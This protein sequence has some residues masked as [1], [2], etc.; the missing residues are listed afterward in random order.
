M[1]ELN[2]LDEILIFKESQS[3]HDLEH[4]FKILLNY[5]SSELNIQPVQANVSIEQREGD[6]PFNNIFSYAIRRKIKN[7]QLT[8]EVSANYSDLYPFIFLR[9]AFYCF[10]PLETL[11]NRAIA[12]FINHIVE[13]NLEKHPRI[14]NWKVL[15]RKNIVDKEYVN[16]QFERFEKFFKLSSSRSKNPIVFFF[17]YTRRNIVLIEKDIDLF[18]EKMAKEYMF[19]MARDLQSDEMIETLRVLIEIFQQAKFIPSKNQYKEYFRSLKNN[20]TIESDLSI[21]KFIENLRWLK[22]YSYIAPNYKVDYSRIGFETFALVCQFHPYL[23]KKNIRIIIEHFPFL[24]YLRMSENSFSLNIIGYCYVPKIYLSDFRYL[25]EFLKSNSYVQNIICINMEE[26][27]NSLNLNYFREFHNRKLLINKKHQK[28]N[29][30][31]EIL[32][33]YSYHIS[34]NPN[35]KPLSLSPLEFLILDRIRYIA[36]TGFGFEHNKKIINQLKSDY[37]N[38]FFSQIDF[39]KDLRVKLQNLHNEQVIKQEFYTYL[40]QFS[41][42]GTYYLKEIFDA[43]IEATEL[44]ESIISDQHLQSL[45]DFQFFLQTNAFN[46]FSKHIKQEKLIQKLMFN[47]LIPL[48]FNNKPLYKK[49]IKKFIFFSEI[50][51][52]FFSLKIFDIKAIEKIVKNESIS[53]TIYSKK[54]ERLKDLKGKF[55]LQQIKIKN[56]KDVILKFL[57]LKPPIIYPSL[58]NTINTTNFAIFNLILIL[59]KTPEVEEKIKEIRFHFPRV[60]SIEGTEILT[61]GKMV[62]IEIFLP[63]LTIREKGILISIFYGIFEE[64]L[65]YILRL[66]SSGVLKI[67]SLK[68]Y[69]D[70]QKNSYFY[71]KDLFS[72]YKMFLNKIFGTISNINKFHSKQYRALKQYLNYKD[73]NLNI[74]SNEVYKRNSWEQLIIKSKEL[75]KLENFHK[76]LNELLIDHTNIKNIKNEWFFNQYIKSIE[77]IPQ[78]QKFGFSSYYLW[79]STDHLDEINKKSLLINTFLSIQHPAELYTNTDSFL[80]NYLFPYH[81]P[82]KSYFN[83]LLKSKKTFSEYILYNIKTLSHI[84]HL[85]YNIAPDGWDLNANHF[86]SF[87]KKIIYKQKYDLPLPSMK[88]FDFSE[89]EDTFLGPDSEDYEHLKNLFTF[90]PTDLKSFLAFEKHHKIDSFQHLHSKNLIFPYI[91]IKNLGLREIFCFIIPSIT[92]QTINSLIKIFGFFNYCFLYEI[93]GEYFI[94]GMNDVQTFENGLY[95]KLYLPDCEFSEYYNA[96]HEVF[97]LLGISRFIILHDLVDG[98]DFLKETYGDLDFLDSYTPLDNLHWNEKDKIWINH[99]LFDENFEFLDVDL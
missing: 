3:N 15:I 21:R 97:D 17:E 68:D 33:E 86:N 67:S 96:F 40:N 19:K 49:E 50:L 89:I 42:S 93:E 90:Q 16:V 38:D 78:L 69:Y 82:N 31:Y 18:H 77:F 8:L 99:K 70:F 98:E 63:N 26:M 62:Y 84:F 52:N 91:N 11:K 32:R 73:Y 4:K 28:Y 1:D 79:F 9:E 2:S 12:I 56:V 47:K 72:Q 61:K 51:Q 57:D 25:L 45:Y 59:N 87:A 46:L 22:N 14:N 24:R 27:K 43:I 76:N 41:S 71:T 58:L 65:V 30:K 83:W 10:L 54:Q 55:P 39:I 80:I 94:E 35:K 13:I 53:S 37:L 81:S 48:Y 44:F 85:N 74:L 7:D 88:K 29:E 60:I 34:K 95:I 6:I 64:D 66:Y 92:P 36:F 23:K 75:N 5:L 20:G